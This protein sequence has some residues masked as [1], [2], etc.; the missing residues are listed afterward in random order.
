MVCAHNLQLCIGFRVY[1]HKRIGYR[2]AVN[3]YT[4]MYI[5][6]FVMLNG[7]VYECLHIKCA[8]KSQSHTNVIRIEEIVNQFIIT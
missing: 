4:R 5:F 6:L 7:I 3:V 1:F 2:F 8:V